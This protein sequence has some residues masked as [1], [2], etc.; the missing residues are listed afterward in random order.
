MTNNL[1]FNSWGFGPKGYELYEGVALVESEDRKELKLI[2]IDTDVS[3]IDINPASS[4]AYL[5]LWEAVSEL[6]NEIANTAS[7]D[8]YS[9]HDV[10]RFEEYKKEQMERINSIYK[11]MISL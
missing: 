8:L 9:F 3:K 5:P 6:L 11:E 1:E 7:E 10:R 4:I 2:S